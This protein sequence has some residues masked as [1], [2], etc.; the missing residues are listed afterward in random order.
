LGI[1]VRRLVLLVSVFSAV[2]AGTIACSSATN[3]SAVGPADTVGSEPSSRPATTPRR[4]TTS[5]RPSTGN[6]PL[7]GKDPCTLL[8]ADGQRKLGISNAPKENDKIGSGRR[9][10]WRLRGPQDTYFFSVVIYDTLGLKD[11]PSS[12]VTKLPN[13]GKHEAVRA[14]EG[15]GPGTCA[16]ELGVTES[17]R[18]GTDIV[19]GT[20]TQKAC[21]LNMQLASLVEPELP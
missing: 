20:D 6:G 16:I 18:V 7:A 4:S 3:G 1:I 11:V 17:S 10:R 5:S 21:D 12:K 13:I 2:L 15:G 14:T 8:S 19:A 9:C